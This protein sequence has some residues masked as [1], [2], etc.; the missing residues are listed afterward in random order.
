VLLWFH[1]RLTAAAER[2][3]AL[4]DELHQAY[5]DPV[6]GL[7]DRSN[8]RQPAAK[9]TRTYT[10]TSLVRCRPCGR[11]MQ[12]RWIH[13]RAAATHCRHGRPSA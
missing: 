11:T 8:H 1:A 9:A 12:P 6:T 4:E 2:L 13:A 7:P 5:T 10:L 3:A